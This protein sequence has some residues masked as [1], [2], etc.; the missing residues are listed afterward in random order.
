MDLPSDVRLYDPWLDPE[1]STIEERYGIFLSW[2]SSYTDVPKFD[3]W[4]Q[5]GDINVLDGRK[6]ADKAS[7]DNWSPKDMEYMCELEVAVRSEFPM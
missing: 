1:P 7:A 5:S 3:V 6:R 4:Y 2:A